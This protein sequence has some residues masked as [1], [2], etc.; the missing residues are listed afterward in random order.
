MVHQIAGR[1]GT[2]GGAP[3][4]RA[5]GH[6]EPVR[7]LVSSPL[8]PLGLEFVGRLVMGIAIDPKGAERDRY[9]GLGQVDTTDFVDEVLGRLS[10]YFAGVR[11]K[12]DVPF[13]LERAGV[14]PLSRRIFQ[15]TARIPYGLTRSYRNVATSSGRA[16]AYRL[17]R[18]RLMANPLPIVVPCHRVVPRR[19]GPGS[20][21][22]GGER[23]GHLL[24]LE[25]K[26]A[27]LS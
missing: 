27:E 10:E 23:K 21:V 24:E 3:G 2:V 25:R 6:A 13:D 16:G 19:S 14:D 26:H 8:G 17:I 20:W 11:R 9:P 4:W 1:L 5:S 22:G 12:L 18:S 7:V 15:E